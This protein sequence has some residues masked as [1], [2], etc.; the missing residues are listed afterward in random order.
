FGVDLS[1]VALDATQR[2]GLVGGL[3]AERAK[4]PRFGVAAEVEP[5]SG[6]G[7]ATPVPAVVA[8]SDLLQDLIGEKPES[9]AT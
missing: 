1:R 6:V 5:S 9:G 8:S 3:A 2:A 7:P 4:E